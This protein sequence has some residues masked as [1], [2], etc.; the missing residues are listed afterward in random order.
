[1]SRMVNKRRGIPVGVLVVVF[2]A[3]NHAQ[4]AAGPPPT[5]PIVENARVRVWDVPPGATAA[6]ALPGRDAVTFIIRGAPPN[7]ETEVR[8]HARGT[9]VPGPPQDAR[10]IV[11]EL[12]DMPVPPLA[13][14]SGYPPAF[15]RP[16]SRKLL[17]NDRVVVWTSTWTTG[18]ATPMHFHD[19]DVVV[20]FLADGTLTSTDAQGKTTA[21]ERHFGDTS[22]NPRARVHTERLD[23]GQGRAM[24]VELK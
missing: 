18:V 19:K 16:G 15:P 13:N 12:Q 2:A 11:I 7:V 23:R 22:F 1:M 6:P 8:Y 4:R 3:A 5:T 10:R 17:E 20:T 21:N 14:T 24:M 9:V